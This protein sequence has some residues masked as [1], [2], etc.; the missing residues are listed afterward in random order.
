MVASPSR[1]E[2]LNAEREDQ[3]MDTIDKF[4]LNCAYL[5]LDIARDALLAAEQRGA[6]AGRIAYLRRRYR[7]A[8]DRVARAAA[9]FMILGE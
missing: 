5:S 9:E 1:A 7:E 6:P 2:T 3:T 4:V 8:Q